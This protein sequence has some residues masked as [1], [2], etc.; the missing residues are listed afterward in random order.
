MRKHATDVAH[1]W[2][3]KLLAMLSPPRP[4]LEERLARQYTG[5]IRLARLLAQDAESL[6]RYP[7]Q[8]VRVLDAS[9]NAGRRAQRIQR[10]FKAVDHLATEPVTVRRGSGRT[11]WEQLHANI[12]ELSEMSEAYLADAYAV[13]R[14]HPEIAGLLLQLHQEAAL[15]RRD[16]VWTLAQLEPTGVE[17]SRAER[18]A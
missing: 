2:W 17:A 8:G 1:P 13:E 18:V 12:S 11:V 4:N 5:E 9:D 7:H 3:R 14:N 16:L 10:A 6:T 15:D